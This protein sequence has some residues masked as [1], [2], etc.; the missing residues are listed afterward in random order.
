MGLDQYVDRV[1]ANLVG[2]GMTDVKL[3]EEAAEPVWRWRKHPNLQ[4]WMEQAYR[5]N[6]G[7]DERFNCVNV[8]LTAEVL[9]ALEKDIKAKA[10]PS[11]DGFFFG[12]DEDSDEEVAEDL[13]AIEA[14]RKS[15]QEGY[16]VFYS[17]WW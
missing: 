9:D 7:K 1:K 13:R 11:T 12:Q 3:P 4:G 10:L 5:D 6:G 17:S 16:K 15:I 14:C 8:R 2:D